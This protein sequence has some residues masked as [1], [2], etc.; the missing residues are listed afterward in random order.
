MRSVSVGHWVLGQQAQQLCSGIMRLQTSSAT[1]VESPAMN[2]QSAHDGAAWGAT[3][4]G[5]KA[6]KAEASRLKA[7]NDCAPLR[8]HRWWALHAQ[9][10]PCNSTKRS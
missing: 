4:S 6:M 3:V 7:Q 2:K 5:G 10:E 9:R 8:S 1:S